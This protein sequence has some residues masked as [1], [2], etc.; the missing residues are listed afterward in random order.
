MCILGVEGDPS[1]QS[2]CLS[3]LCNVEVQAEDLDE[4]NR[5]MPETSN[6]VCVWVHPRTPVFRTRT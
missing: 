1:E 4:H 6:P 5:V 2:T 3:L